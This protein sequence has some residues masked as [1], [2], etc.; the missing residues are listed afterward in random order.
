MEFTTTGKK[1]RA[2]RSTAEG[3]DE[4]TTMEITYPRKASTHDQ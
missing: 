1:F 3:D 4:A 2:D